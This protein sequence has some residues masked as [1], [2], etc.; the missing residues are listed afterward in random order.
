[1]MADMGYRQIWWGQP[2]E[3]ASTSVSNHQGDQQNCKPLSQEY[4]YHMV[5][6]DSRLKEVFRSLWDF[7]WPPNYHSSF[8]K[9]SIF[10]VSEIILFPIVRFVNLFSGFKL[11]FAIFHVIYIH[12]LVV[13]TTVSKIFF[14]KFITENIAYF[15]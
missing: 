4:L 13:I 2:E 1:M 3:P 12:F 6:A 7:L 8:L 14:E 10:F 5:T 11:I 15:W 9:F